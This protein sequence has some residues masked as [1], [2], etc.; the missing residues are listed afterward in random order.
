MFNACIHTDFVI[1]SLAMT[2]FPPYVWG[3]SEA[4]LITMSYRVSGDTQVDGII[5]PEGHTCT[6]QVFLYEQYCPFVL[7]LYT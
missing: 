3:L 7:L 5:S 2:N 6:L 1:M 4:S